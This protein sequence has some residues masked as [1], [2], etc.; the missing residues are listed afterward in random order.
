MGQGTASVAP[1]AGTGGGHGG[2]LTPR[3]FPPLPAGL[4]LCLKKQVHWHVIGLGTGP[5]VHSVFF[6]GHTFL[7][8]GHRLSSLEIS[9]AT[10][11][12]AQ[13]M[14]G[15]AGQFRM[16]CQIP[17]H[18]QGN[19]SLQEPGGKEVQGMAR[20]LCGAAAPRPSLFNHPITTCNLAH[21]RDG[22]CWPAWGHI[23]WG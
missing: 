20:A 8:R 3:C 16:F 4:T 5:E 12:T 11:L 2:V 22:I 7:V 14:P 21:D 9:P 18:Q 19:L 23:W 1:R 13:T 10:Y 6:E 15:T 17:S